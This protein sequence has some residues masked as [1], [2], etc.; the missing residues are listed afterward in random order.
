MRS[1]GRSLELKGNSLRASPRVRGPFRVGPD[2]DYGDTPAS[3]EDEKDLH[4]A[5][6][7]HVSSKTLRMVEFS[8]TKPG[9][10]ASRSANRDGG[11]T[12][13]RA[14]DKVHHLRLPGQ[15]RRARRRRHHRSKG[16]S[17]GKQSDRR[18]TVQGAAP[19]AVSPHGASLI[20]KDEESMI[21]IGEA[22]HR[23]LSGPRREHCQ[24]HRVHQDELQKGNG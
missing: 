17:I 11:E 15:E 13:A 24:Q 22:T 8:Q 5:P 1:R 6:A 23:R 19:R 21:V 3:A 16:Q 18:E 7:S 2:I 20:D 14:Q 12:K 9:R 10:V 4:D